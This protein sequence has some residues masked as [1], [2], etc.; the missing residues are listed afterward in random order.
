MSAIDE[1]VES[2]RRAR[3]VIIPFG[4]AFSAQGSRVRGSNRRGSL[5]SRVSASAKSASAKSAGD[6]DGLDVILFVFRQ[7]ILL[8]SA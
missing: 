3:A 4:A 8:S 6:N 5:P 1:K 2:G 7:Q